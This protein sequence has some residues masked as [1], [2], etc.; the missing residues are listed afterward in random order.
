MSATDRYALDA[1]PGRLGRAQDLLNTVGL[2]GHDD[3]LTD[4]QLAGEW[5][6]APL[7]EPD[8]QRLRTFRTDLQHLVS[9][10]GEPSQRWVVEVGLELSSDAAVELTSAGKGAQQ[11]IAAVLAGIYE[12]QLLDTWRRLK[13]CRNPRC[14]AAFYDRSKNNSRVWHSLATCGN[15]ANLKAHRARAKQ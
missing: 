7:T 2:A 9:G 10:S 5:A 1:A 4:P 8:L 11:I 3:L 12:A 15:P 6:G 13:T 14:V